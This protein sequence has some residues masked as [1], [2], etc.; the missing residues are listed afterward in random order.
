[1]EDSTD[2]LLEQRDIAGHLPRHVDDC[3][4][5]GMAASLEAVALILGSFGSGEP[6]FDT[7]SAYAA[8]ARWEGMVWAYKHHDPLKREHLG[9]GMWSDQKNLAMD[10]A[11]RL[12]E[13]CFSLTK[14]S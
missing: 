5:E 2:H 12:S 4:V 6:D 14:E 10:G 8:V 13:K 7:L 1:M 11:T 9:V 3:N